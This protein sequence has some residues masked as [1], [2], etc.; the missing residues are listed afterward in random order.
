[1]KRFLIV[2]LYKPDGGGQYDDVQLFQTDNKKIADTLANQLVEGTPR[3]GGYPDKAFVVNT[4]RPGKLVKS[5]EK[6][7]KE[8]ADFL[9]EMGMDE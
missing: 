6:A 5:A 7:L 9:K 1:M 8:K 4:T 3:D 2:H